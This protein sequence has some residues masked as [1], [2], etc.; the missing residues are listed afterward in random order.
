MMVSSAQH[1]DGVL[2][3]VQLN[4]PLQGSYWLYRNSYVREFGSQKVDISIS[5]FLVIQ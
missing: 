3:L 4:L 1:D 2:P 5:F